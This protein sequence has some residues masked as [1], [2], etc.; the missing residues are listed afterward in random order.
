LTKEFREKNELNTIE[1]ILCFLQREDMGYCVQSN[2]KPSAIPF[3]LKPTDFMEFAK[4][5]FNEN[6]EKS[7]VNALSN[8]KRAIDC[9]ISSLLWL[10]GYY[11]IS[12]DKHWDFP[13]SADFLLRI[14]IIAPNILKKINKKRNE[15]EHEFKKPTREDVVDFLDVAELFLGFTDQFLNKTYDEFD[16]VTEEDYPLLFLNLISEKGLIEMCFEENEQTKEEASISVDDEEN[17]I[18][19]LRHLVKCIMER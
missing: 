2:S 19:I 18:T 8:V 15:L 3:D 13:Q 4:S 10:F 7:L 5:D 12:K 11:K 9:R 14:G 16:I 6:T 17:Y 1:K